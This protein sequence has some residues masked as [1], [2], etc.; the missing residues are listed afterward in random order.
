[1]PSPSLM[2]RRVVVTGALEYDQTFLPGL[3][4]VAAVPVGGDQRLTNKS[5]KTALVELIGHALGRDQNPKTYHFDPI[6]HELDSVFLE[7]EANGE[8][9]TIQ[10]SLVH[11][12]AK[13]TI[14]ST[15]YFHGIER[16]PGEPIPRENLSEVILAALGIPR[17]RVKEAKGDLTPLSFPLLMRAFVLHQDD[18]FGKILDKVIPDQRVTDVLGFVTG[19]TPLDRFGIEESLA[20]KQLEAAGLAAYLDSAAR[21]LRESGVPSLEEIERRLMEATMTA[22]QAEDD[23][24][25]LQG[26]ISLKSEKDQPTGTGR[27]EELR[28]SV[29]TAKRQ[30]SDVE[31][32]LVGASNEIQ[33]LTDVVGS[34]RTDLQRVR[35]IRAS[36]VILSSIDFSVCPRCLL[37]ITHD[38]KAREDHGRCSLCNRLVRATSD[39]TPRVLPHAQDIQHQVDEAVA[40]LASARREHESLKGR[41]ALLRERESTLSAELNRETAAFVSPALDD[42]AGITHRLASAR[43]E[44]SRL[45]S[46]ASQVRRLNAIRN[47]LDTVRQLEADL[48]DALRNAREPLRARVELL[49]KAYANVLR[50]IEFPNFVNCDIDPY[51]LLPKING[52]SYVHVGTALRGLAVVAYHLAL[53]D[54]SLSVETLFPRLL[55]I[56]SP[57]VGDLNEQN[58]IRLLRYLALLGVTEEGTEHPWQIILTTR[59]TVPELEAYI[60]DRISAE[61]DRMLLKRRGR[62][63]PPT[64]PTAN[65]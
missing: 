37:E 50:R 64:L 29:L 32:H 56:D 7:V 23:R 46:L 43:G 17:V 28:R 38:M 57:A 42:L 22:D 55:V 45:T 41:S 14:R 3:N 61:P 36:R 11:L 30:I 44:M 47:S 20:E 13:L 18:S 27:L 59:K 54:V 5:G 48:Q 40:M 62:V 39:Q 49:R 33:K 10:R 52:E 58:H 65:R 35:R 51:T 24:R 31:A 9:I 2:I 6:S 26:T 63:V 1:M 4:V 19:V 15:P 21:F 60:I 8:L 34:L 25:A 16:T 53:L 12:S